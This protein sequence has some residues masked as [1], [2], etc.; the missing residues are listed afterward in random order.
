[1]VTATFC[2]VVL[3]LTVLV[4]IAFRILK[5][6]PDKAELVRL[7]TREQ[8]F[9]DA[10]FQLENK[11]SEIESLQIEKA[12]LEANL[13]NERTTAD[14]KL[15]L[16][17]DSEARLKTEFENLATKIFEDKGHAITEQNRERISGLLQPLKEQLESFRQ[18]I[19]EVH[20]NDTERSAMLLEKVRQL[21][22]LSNKVSD[23]ANNL[24]KA[25]KGDAKK[26]GDWGELIVERIFEASGLEKGREYDA[27]VGLRADDGSLKKPDFIVYLPGNKAVIV[28][29]KVSLTA[30]ERF[31]SADEDITKAEEA[32]DAH[33]QSVR[34]HIAELQSK[35]Y[36]QLLGNNSLDFVIMCIPLEPAYHSALQSDKN[37]V[38]DLAKINVVITGPTTLMITLKLIA[39]IWRREHEN[40]NVEV[41]ADRAGRMYDQVV[42]IVEAMTEAQK[43]L[44][45]VA[46]SFELALK[47]LQDGKGNLVGRV[48][49]IRRLGAKVNKQLPAAILEAA[50]T[51]EE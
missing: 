41:I 35:D 25:I 27:Q 37:L 9:E 44:T 10:T 7:R 4:F 13:E 42:L 16:L 48:E 36:S 8:D 29:S 45:G 46:D 47:R 19:D 38:Y 24:A 32:L 34:N 30:Y 26:Q 14:E 31:C 21:Q 11:T 1:M 33:L 22:E 3:A 15:K 12:K 43:K 51:E 18:R 2:I 6:A 5:D 39:Q 50:V 23:E 49:E 17:Q 40:R 28:D 20:K